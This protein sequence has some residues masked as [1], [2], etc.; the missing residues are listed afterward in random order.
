[1]NLYSTGDEFILSAQLPGMDPGDVE[2]TATSDTVTLRGERKRP[3][4][5]QDESYR[6]QERFMG[7][8]S[9][10]ITL[11][12]RVDESRVSARFVDGVLTVHLPRAGG[13]KPR[14][15]A[16]TSQTAAEPREPR[17]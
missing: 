14:H 6:R 17:S 7:R 11:P 10:T 4:G 5:V 15:I 16:V 12:D 13:A 1:M 9:R 8:W 2:L 3:E